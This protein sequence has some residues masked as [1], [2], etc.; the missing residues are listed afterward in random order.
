MIPQTHR[1]LIA[2]AA[3]LLVIATAACGGLSIA[4]LGNVRPLQIN[5]LTPTGTTNAPLLPLTIGGS[6]FDPSGGS[7]ISVRFI[8]ENGAPA[9]T[10][11]VTAVNSNGL[12]TSVPPFFDVASGNSTSVVVDV[13][14]VEISGS[15]V[16]TSNII[17]GL[18]VD[19]L[20]AVPAGVPPGALTSTFLRASLNVSSIPQLATLGTTLGQYNSELSALISAANQIANNPSITISVPTSGGPMLLNAQTLTVSDQILQA[21]ASAIAS[22]GQLPVPMSRLRLEQKRAKNRLGQISDCPTGPHDPAAFDTSVCKIDRF[23]ENV[24]GHDPGINSALIA[25]AMAPVI[26][27]SLD[28]LAEFFAGAPNND[29]AAKIA[30]ASLEP[31]TEAYIEGDQ[32]A[33]M[34]VTNAIVESVAIKAVER[35]SRTP[36]LGIAD[37]AWTVWQLGTTT[38]PLKATPLS[39]TAVITDYAGNAALLTPSGDQLIRVPPQQGVFPIDSL[40]L[41]VPPSPSPS[42]NPTPSQSPSPS[43]SPSPNG[44]WFYHWNCNGD[45]SCL[46]TNP[47]NMPTGNQDEGPGAGGISSCNS[48]LQFADQFWGPAAVDACDQIPVEILP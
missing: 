21:V 17:T 34:D 41:V 30:W 13:Q 14:V 18:K 47:T 7:A 39:H 10:V 42:P 23:W 28:S 44:D 25:L 35:I 24:G 9:V 19:S 27:E 3:S 32:P 26:D 43:P 4:P 46:A 6:G 31:L 36:G 38:W 29:D 1:L 48:L 22:Q 5:S 16:S 45:S 15:T 11:P 8:P 37:K 2:S 33:P 40:L 20:P 12:Q